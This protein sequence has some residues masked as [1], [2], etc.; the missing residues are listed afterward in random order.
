VVSRVLLANIKKMVNMDTLVLRWSPEDNFTTY[1]PSTSFNRAAWAHV[2]NVRSLRLDIPLE[3][4]M[5][6]LSRVPFLPSLQTL[7]L[8][9]R[10]EW[11]STAEHGLIYVRLAAF[12]NAQSS[13]LTYLSIDTP[14]A[15]SGSYGLYQAIGKL[16]G[17]ALGVDCEAVQPPTDFLDRHSHQLQIVK[18]HF[19]GLMYRKYALPQ[20]D[21]FFETIR[22]KFRSADASCCYLARRW[23]RGRITG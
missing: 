11:A 16:T 18:M 14:D 15:M 2:A 4:V 21:A 10:P 13:T 20:P 9:L 6:P 8:S 3:F 23:V 19:P 1:K 12:I 5:K 7:N 17:V 22:A